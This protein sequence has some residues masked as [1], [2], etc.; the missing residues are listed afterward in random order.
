[1]QNTQLKEEMRKKLITQ[2]RE[3]IEQQRKIIEKE[4]GHG[5]EKRKKKDRR[6]K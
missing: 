1:M 3:K 6:H 2:A 5:Y 4:T